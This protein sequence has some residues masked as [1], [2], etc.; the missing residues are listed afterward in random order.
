VALCDFL[1][2][3]SKNPQLDTTADFF[4]E[5]IPF[6]YEISNYIEGHSNDFVSNMREIKNLILRDLHWHIQNNEISSNT[7]LIT[8]F[9]FQAAISPITQFDDRICVNSG[10]ILHQ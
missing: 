7:I 5:L 8:I 1:Q 2:K 9:R 6:A 10:G 3:E 4:E